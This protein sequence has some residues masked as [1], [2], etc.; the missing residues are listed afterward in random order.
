MRRLPERGVSLLEAMLALS[1]F[2]L[3]GVIGAYAL[4]GSIQVHSR[5]SSQ[6]AAE[7]SVT[8]AVSRLD[9]E[10]LAASAFEIGTAD[11]PAHLGGGGLDGQAVWFLSDVDPATGQSKRTVD[12]SPFW[13]KTILYYLV[14]PNNHDAL[15][16]YT[17]A[18][19]VAPSGSYDDRCPHKVLVRK[20][21]DVGSDTDLSD[22]ATAESLPSNVNAWLTQPDA[23]DVSGL[24]GEVDLEQVEVVAGD[25]LW[26]TVDLA[27]PEVTVTVKAAPWGDLEKRLAVGSTSLEG[28]PGVREHRYTLTLRH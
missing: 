7:Q 2:T 3:L 11:V 26:F 24:A 28:Q 5:V 20:V 17:C 22:E 4:R 23:F 25:L 6:Q 18:G 12:G 8:R 27:A 21:L 13:Q 14:V 10:L 9:R 19:G 16:G 15:C 1:L